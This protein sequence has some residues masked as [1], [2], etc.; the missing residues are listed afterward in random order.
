MRSL[1]KRAGVMMAGALVFL[2]SD[3]RAE[4]FSKAYAFKADTTLEVG[5][6][7]P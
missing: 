1:A 4:L 2:A 5:T 7:M 3:A 6:E